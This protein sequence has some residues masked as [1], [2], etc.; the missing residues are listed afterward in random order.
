VIKNILL[1]RKKLGEKQLLN[2]LL[3]GEQE[4]P[5]IEIE[6]GHQIKS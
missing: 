2:T 5:G 1:A 6:V 3:S 4:L